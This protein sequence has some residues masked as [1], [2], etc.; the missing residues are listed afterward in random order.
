M[1]PNEDNMKIILFSKTGNI[2]DEIDL[3]DNTEVKEAIVLD[4]RVFIHRKIDYEG[5]PEPRKYYEVD[6]YDWMNEL[7]LKRIRR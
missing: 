6:A 1:I 5:Y 4:K 7:E 3:S 2:I